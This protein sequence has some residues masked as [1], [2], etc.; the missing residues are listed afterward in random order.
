MLS[1]GASFKVEWIVQVQQ[2][3]GVGGSLLVQSQVQE[4]TGLEFLELEKSCL[5]FVKALPSVSLVLFTFELTCGD[6]AP[7]LS[8]PLGRLLDITN[9]AVM[10]SLLLLLM[11]EYK[12]RRHS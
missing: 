10:D 3:P 8:Q 4:V 7:Y 12:V 5:K 9:V 6:V 11:M 1:L 2:K